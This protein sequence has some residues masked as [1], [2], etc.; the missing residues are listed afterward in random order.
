MNN[1]NKVV[2][3][4]GLNEI[5]ESYDVFILDQ[6]GVMHDG[7]KGYEDS[8]DC[9]NKLINKKKILTIISNSSK[10]KENTLAR[11][12]QLGFNPIFF[13]EVMT[14]GEMIW[15]SLMNKNYLQT[16][17]LG[18]NC[19]H[20]FDDS[21]ED[22]KFILKGLKGF[23]CVQD[24]EKADFILGC[25]P[26]KNKKIIDYFPLLDVAKKNNLIFICANPDFETIKKGSKKLVFCMGTIAELYKNI[27]GEVFSL[28]KPSIEIYL[29]IIKKIPN[30]KKSRILA[31]GD[32]LYHDIKGAI[33]FGIDSLLITSY[34]I[35]QK[36][37]DEKKPIW[38]S[39]DHFLQNLNIE[40]TFICSKFKY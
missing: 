25:T 22:A 32:S 33:N 15:Q 40:P 30:V 16:K 29:E 38:N 5:I 11:L 19:F 39:N 21:Q 18:K 17:N 24:I 7:H 2:N 3:I 4:S 23:N 6:W 34:G 9:I 27:G 26:F 36:I 35:H 8:I 20:I 14:S 37:F 28:G 10:R 13:K 1:R 31:I 12:P